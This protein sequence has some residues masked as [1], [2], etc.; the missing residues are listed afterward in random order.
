[1]LRFGLQASIVMREA[2]AGQIGSHGM[3]PQS[4]LRKVLFI[5]FD[6]KLHS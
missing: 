1:L 2:E 4:F 5:G 3:K 6:A